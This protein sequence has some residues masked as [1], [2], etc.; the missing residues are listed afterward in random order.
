MSWMTGFV[1]TVDYETSVDT[2]P[3]DLEVPAGLYGLGEC[4]AIKS[5]KVVADRSLIT[6]HREALACTAG[7]RTQSSWPIHVFG[8][9]E[10]CTPPS[11]NGAAFARYRP[12]ISPARDEQA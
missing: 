6:T 11:L 4:F 1:Y 5:L 7:E 9:F 12:R 2:S 10:S 3:D 8:S